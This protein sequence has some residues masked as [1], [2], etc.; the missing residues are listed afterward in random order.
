MSDYNFNKEAFDVLLQ[1]SERQD[2]SEWDSWRKKFTGDIFLEGAQLAGA[3]LNRVNLNQVHLSHACME[4][5]DFQ[6]ANLQRTWLCDANLKRCHLYRANLK[7][8]N[9]Q[10]ARLQGANMIEACLLGANVRYAFLKAANLHHAFL[11]GADFSYAIVDGE[12]LLDTDK[13]DQN[14]NFAGVGLASAR[15]GQRLIEKYKIERSIVFPPE[16][17]QVGL[18]IL[19]FFSTVLKR[20][21]PEQKVHVKIVQEDLRIKLIIDPIDGDRKI[22]EKTLENYGLV[23]VGQMSP[24]QFTDNN[25]LLLDLKELKN[26]L[27]Y[28][29]ARIESQ[30]DIIESQK[31]NMEMFKQLLHESIT[32][33]QPS[34]NISVPVTS[35]STSNITQELTINSNF[36]NITDLFNE[37]RN[38]LAKDTDEYE[39]IEN[40]QN[41]IAEINNS[42][43]KDEVGTSLAMSKLCK[44][45]DNAEKAETVFGRIINNTK[46]GI[47]VARK[48][49]GHYND[50]AQWCGLPQVPKPFSK[51]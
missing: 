23:L 5:A 45:I 35:K 36:Q 32:K 44:F 34:I 37:I 20:E 21:Y 14:T 28:A 12:T 18:S 8:A 17:Q 1:C 41:S 49:A 46:S 25:S 40:L 3:Y 38:Q 43:S 4:G 48:I 9:I 24:E 51:K 42:K 39:I 15:A 2:F 26:E 30:K 33:P 11:Q 31:S 6:E 19:N 27:N 50:I 47:D 13:I 10:G 16:Y 7:D 29:K 22:I